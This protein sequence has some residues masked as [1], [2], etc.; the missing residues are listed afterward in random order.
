MGKNNDCHNI[1]ELI[2]DYGGQVKRKNTKLCEICDYIMIS[3]YVMPCIW[4][5]PNEKYSLLI[6]I[7]TTP[8][9]SQK[10]KYYESYEAIC[11]FITTFLHEID[12]SDA[13]MRHLTSMS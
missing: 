10:Q 11:Q 4:F 2:L 13:Y 6:R 1:R 12:I 9:I 3:T 8:K 7:I 5:E